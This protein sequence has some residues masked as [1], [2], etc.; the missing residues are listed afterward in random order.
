MIR[1]LHCYKNQQHT[2]IVSVLLKSGKSHAKLK[3]S[4]KSHDLVLVLPGAAIRCP[5]DVVV[6][7]N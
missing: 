1:L 3:R 7:K 6:T 4:V 5:V 2:E